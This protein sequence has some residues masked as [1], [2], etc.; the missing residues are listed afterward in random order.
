MCVFFCRTIADWLRLWKNPSD[1]VTID[2]KEIVIAVVVLT[3][4]TSSSM[5]KQKKFFRKPCSRAYLDSHSIPY[6]HWS[7]HSTYTHYFDENEFHLSW[8]KIIMSFITNSIDYKL[9]IHLVAIG[10]GHVDIMC[11]F[12]INE[13]KKY[14]KFAIRIHWGEEKMESKTE[15][16]FFEIN[17]DQ[18]CTQ[19]SN[20]QFINNMKTIEIFSIQ[21]NAYFYMTHTYT[22]TNDWPCQRLIVLSDS[23]QLIKWQ[24]HQN[25]CIEY[26]DVDKGTIQLLHDNCP[27]NSEKTEKTKRIY[28]PIIMQCV[29]HRN[30]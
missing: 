1:E 21:F 16:L 5:K 22:S 23:I 8:S 11:Q 2:K 13:W 9:S 20:L 7:I 24:N 19:Q 27:L 25:L 26:M 17:S 30:N 10:F 29:T 6:I 12:S 28:F 4:C 18:S 3:R 15:Q 14:A